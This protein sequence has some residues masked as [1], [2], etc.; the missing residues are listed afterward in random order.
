MFTSY[1]T[2]ALAA[3]SAV[4][5]TVLPRTAS[6]SASGPAPSS[7]AQKWLEPY[8]TYH[9]RYLSLGCSSKHNT[10]F[11]DDCCHPLLKWEKLTGAR[12]A[13]CVPGALSTTAAHTATKT[14]SAVAATSTAEECTEDDE[15]CECVDDEEEECEEGDEDCVCEDEPESSSFAPVSTHAS[16]STHSRSVV[17]VTSYST[18][19]SATA[20]STLVASSTHTS[21]K[22][23]VTSSSESTTVTS[24]KATTSSAPKTTETPTSTVKSTTAAGTVT[25][26]LTKQTTG[27]LTGGVATFFY[28][29]GVAGACGKVHPDS[30]PIAAID[31]K[32][33]GFDGAKSLLCGMQVKVTNEKNGKS[34]LVTIADDCPTC[35]NENSIDLSHGAFTAIA[36]EEEGEV[37]V[38]IEF[39]GRA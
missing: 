2:L 7:Y 27:K 18:A 25:A 29:G 36:T 9:A 37:P 35:T 39:A 5:A 31:S 6:S 14:T 16:T 11:F 22:S 4:S 17:I 19:T 26:A 32:R 15:D 34:V 12:K 3:V 10:A 21:A 33:Y 13:Y 20:T 30:A 23:T 28:Q 24:S 38:T 8:A 1:V